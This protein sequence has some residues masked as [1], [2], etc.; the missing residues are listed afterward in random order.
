MK[1]RSTAPI[2]NAARSTVRGMAG[3]YLLVTAC[4]I[5]RHNG[6]LWTEAA[7]LKDLALHLCYV[8]SV[9]LACP[10]RESAPPTF[11]AE[12][13]PELVDRIVF[14]AIPDS[15]SRKMKLLY[16]PACVGKLLHLA[17]RSEIFH[18]TVADHPVLYGCMVPYFRRRGRLGII[19]V[20]ESSPWRRQNGGILDKGLSKLSERGARSACS[21]AHVALATQPAYLKELADPSNANHVTPAVW[22]DEAWILPLW[23][24]NPLLED[25]AQKLAR[26]I[27]VAFFGRLTPEKGPDLFIRACRL[28]VENGIHVQADVY[29]DGYFRE[30]LESLARGIESSIHFCQ[31]I[32]YGEQFLRVLSSYHALV[33]P[34]RSDEQPRIVFDGFSQGVP[35]LASTAPGLDVVR[36]GYSGLRFNTGDVDDLARVLKM[37]SADPVLWKTLSLGAYE[38]GKGFTHAEMHRKRSEILLAS[39][40]HA[41]QLKAFEYRK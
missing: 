11:S 29:G 18:F 17:R 35:I 25:K 12:L 32:E 16:G 7:W 6:S 2:G 40:P 9:T 31:P 8:R 3:A 1:L 21:H 30:Q 20:I 23:E 22:V 4:P 28:L 15:E 14:K 5:Y 38:S 33:V 36:D 19:G 26:C 39:F 13:P 34:S 10:I 41:R 24:L 37:L 27:H